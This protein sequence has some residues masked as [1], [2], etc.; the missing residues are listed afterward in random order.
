MSALADGLDE[1]RR[2]LWLSARESLTAA[3][4]ADPADPR[5]VL[6]LAVGHLDRDQPDQALV[7]LETT[8]ALR[9]ATSPWAAR[10]AWLIAAARLAGGDPQ[11]ALGAVSALDA[12]TARRV[13]AAVALKAGDY[14]RGVR[15]LLLDRIPVRILRPPSSPGR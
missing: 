4:A 8:P 2:G 9:A 1:L 10:G 7:L 15:A 11:G 13:E 6:A 12:T 3:A 14:G 5:P